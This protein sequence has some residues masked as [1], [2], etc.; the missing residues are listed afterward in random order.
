MEVVHIT[1][2]SDGQNKEGEAKGYASFKKEEWQ[3]C[4]ADIFTAFKTSKASFRL[5][6]FYYIFLFA[7]NHKI[8]P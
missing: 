3:N 7:R 2:F 8:F 4:S 5:L 6:P 1:L